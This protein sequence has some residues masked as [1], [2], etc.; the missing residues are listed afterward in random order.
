MYEE[1]PPDEKKMAEDSVRLCSNSVPKTNKK[2]N[3]TKITNLLYNMQVSETK[4]YKC[5][6]SVHACETLT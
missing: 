6:T 4:E 3:Y 1:P 2:I 5:K